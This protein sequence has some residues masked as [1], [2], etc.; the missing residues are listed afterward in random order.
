MKG[1]E[2]QTCFWGKEGFLRDLKE[3]LEKKEEGKV[4]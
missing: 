1:Q 3:V 2:G 4:L